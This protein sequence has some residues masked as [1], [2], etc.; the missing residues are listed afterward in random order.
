M[1]K[2]RQESAAVKMVTKGQLE[3]SRMTGSRNGKWQAAEKP[4]AEAA[5]QV[6]GNAESIIFY[7]EVCLPECVKCTHIQVRRRCQIPWN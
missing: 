4:T 3:S 6:P 7:V 1:K 5:R 2:T